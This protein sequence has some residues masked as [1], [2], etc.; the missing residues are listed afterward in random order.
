MA[1]WDRAPDY[2]PWV[3]AV[4]R[5][6]KSTGTAYI[7]GETETVAAHW[8][9]FPAPK[10]LLTWA[11]SNR[12][13]PKARSWQATTEAIAMLWKGKPRPA[14]PGRFGNRATV[15]SSAAGALPRDMLRGPGLSGKVGAR[16]GLGHP[17]QKPLWLME[18]LIKAS[19]PSE[20]LVLDLFAG[21]ATA[22]VAAHRLGRRWIAVEKNREWTQVSQRRL[23]REGIEAKIIVHEDQARDWTSW[24]GGIE[25]ALGDFQRKIQRLEEQILEREAL[26]KGPVST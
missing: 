8:R 18:R 23:Q 21:T 13:S 22:S 20:G 4:L 6:L 1:D 17:A 12:V 25:E 9:A 19:S 11:I 14:T 3:Q 7:F 10:R 2:G 15:Y 16:E 5:V 26:L 24:R